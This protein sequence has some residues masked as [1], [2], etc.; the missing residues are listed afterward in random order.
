MRRDNLTAFA[1][2]EKYTV[3]LNDEYGLRTYI[4]E[5]YPDFED[6]CEKCYRLRLGKAAA[7]A[8]QDGYE[9]FTT[10]LLI[11]PYQCHDTVK[12][13]CE[14]LAEKHGVKFLYRDFRPLF[15]ETQAKAR[16]AGIYMQKYCGCI[17]SEEERYSKH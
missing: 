6:R 4:K 7:V 8:A 10:T 17:F 14:A 3:T 13:V 11:S 12:K 16:E 5:I 2:R 15:K 1:A 9:A